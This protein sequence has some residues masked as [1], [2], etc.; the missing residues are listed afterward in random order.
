MAVNYEFVD[1][2]ILSSTN[3]NLRIF[4]NEPYFELYKAALFPF[5]EEMHQGKRV[6]HGFNLA[7]VQEIPKQESAV[8]TY[9][10]NGRVSFKVTIYAFAREAINYRTTFLYNN[11]L[12][13]GD[14][15]GIV[16]IGDTNFVGSFNPRLLND[17]SIK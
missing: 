13:P 3:F 5:G 4:Y 14:K 1:E 2:I 15:M 8:I 7:W 9:F 17:L 11:L 12:Q 16:R 6:E 10:I